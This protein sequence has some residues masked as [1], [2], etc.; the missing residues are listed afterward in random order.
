M[1]DDTEA[2]QGLPEG[3][4]VLETPETNDAPDTGKEQS[5]EPEQEAPKPK[6]KPWFQ[7]RIDTVTREKYDAIRRA[8]NAEALVERFN[9]TNAG[10]APAMP[11]MDRLVEQRAAELARTADFNAKCDTVYSSGKGDFGDWDATL[12][13]FGMLGGLNQPFLEAV[14]Q[15]PDAHKVF[16]RLGRTWTPLPA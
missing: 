8:E 1:S 15:L 13:N 3:E 10:E 6:H 7:E 14:T 12:A 9:R 5:E 16:T 11:D 4:T 2:E